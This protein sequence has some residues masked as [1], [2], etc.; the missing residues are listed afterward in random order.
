MLILLFCNILKCS[1]KS[2]MYELFSVLFI[3]VVGHM[4]TG[5]P[6]HLFLPILPVLGSFNAKPV[7]HN[8]V[9]PKPSRV[10]L[11]SVFCYIPSAKIVFL[12]LTLKSLSYE[13]NRYF[14]CAFQTMCIFLVTIPASSH[15]YPENHCSE[16]VFSALTTPRSHRTCSEDLL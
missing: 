9:Y 13:I 6:W 10:N 12:S 2:K 3:T 5:Y 11:Q 15:N 4:L 14:G 7:P 1:L 16:P 8:E